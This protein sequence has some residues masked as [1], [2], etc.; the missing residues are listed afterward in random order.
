MIHIFSIVFK[1]CRWASRL[2]GFYP[3]EVLSFERAK[4]M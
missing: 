3:L 1:S 2:A 4:Y